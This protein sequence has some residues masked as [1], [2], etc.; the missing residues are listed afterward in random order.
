MKALSRSL[1]NRNAANSP[2][3]VRLARSPAIRS[4][5]QGPRLQ[6]KPKL[7]A[8]N[9]PAEGEA[10]RVADQVMRVPAPVD[11]PILRQTEDDDELVQTKSSS[12]AEPTPQG[13]TDT[14]AESVR[15]GGTPLP[16]SER[17]FFEPRFGRDFR[18]VRVHADPDAADAAR[19]INAR[20]FTLG[21]DIGFA[22]GA[23]DTGSAEG[24]RLIAHELTHVVQQGRAPSRDGHVEGEG[25]TIR[26]DIAEDKLSSTPVEEIMA[27]DNYFE[28]GIETIEFYGAELAIIHYDD[29]AEIRL[30]LVPGYVEAPFEGVDYRT[31]STAHMVISPTAPSRGTGSINFIPRGN[32]A[33]LPPDFTF[34]DLP[35]LASEIGRT[36]TFTHHSSGRIVPTEVNTLTAPRLSQALREA[37]AE[38]VRRFDAMSEG[39]IEILTKLEIVMIL[40]SI[41]GALAEGAARA[42]AARAGTATAGAA[43]ARAQSRLARLFASLLKT[44]G[45][46]ESITVEGVQFSG[47]SAA[48]RS[49]GKELIVGRIGILNVGRVPAQGRLIHA[50]FERAAIQAA[51]Q[52]G[53]TSARVAIELVQNPR[54]AAYLE[55]QGYAYQ[56][57]EH[58]S[59]ATRYLTKLFTF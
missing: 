34:G 55:S 58:A 54:W 9:D 20:A 52:A 30:G 46:Q 19:S 2:A 56:V 6:S 29:G 15:A 51:R 13:A 3:A 47:V 45:V 48:L 33:T 49:A 21:N 18:D 41:Y 22:G 12:G 11:P 57:I 53:A 28:H 40:A 5:V 7:G 42:A 31:A 27:D 59:G 36:I 39:N 4:I 8:A 10:E 38:Y 16:S 35:K 25:D 32:E 26:R 17:A 43:V 37:E 1:R 14:V 23:Y 44:G 24:R 50:A